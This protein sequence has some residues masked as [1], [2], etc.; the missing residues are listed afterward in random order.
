MLILFLNRNAHA[1]YDERETLLV[2]IEGRIPFVP[3]EKRCH[4][5][6]EHLTRFYCVIPASCRLAL[7]VIKI[8]KVRIWASLGFLWRADCISYCDFLGCSVALS[9]VVLLGVSCREVSTPL[10][11]LLFS[12]KEHAQCS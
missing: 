2:C 11:M 3:L 1:V 10:V 7:W 5:K 8:L 4:E 12:K 9:P 6:C